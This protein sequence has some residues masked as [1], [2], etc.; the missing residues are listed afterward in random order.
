MVNHVKLEIAI[1]IVAEKIANLYRKIDLAST[2][3]EASFYKS[4]LDNAFYEK[5]LVAVGNMDAIN[6]VLK[7]NKKGAK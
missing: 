3:E 7:E 4:E 5:E 6:S 2:E 1:Q